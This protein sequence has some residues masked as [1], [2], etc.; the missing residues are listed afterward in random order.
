MT[1][2]TQVKEVMDSFAENLSH[3]LSLF[4]DDHDPD[5]EMRS[6]ERRIAYVVLENGRR[7]YIYIKVKLED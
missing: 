5:L 3:I 4:V 1:N 7:A 2:T 6:M